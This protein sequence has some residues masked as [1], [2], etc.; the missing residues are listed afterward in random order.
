MLKCRRP[1]E[2]YVE[3]LGTSDFRQPIHQ[4]SL[5][6]GTD[7][8]VIPWRRSGAKRKQRDRCPR[9]KTRTFC[10]Y[11]NG[12]DLI[13]V[14]EIQLF[15]IT[16]PFRWAPASR[17]YL[18]LSRRHSGTRDGLHIDLRTAGLRGAIGQPA[19]IRRNRAALLVVGRG[20]EGNWPPIA[21]QRQQIK[22][23]W[24]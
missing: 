22:V 12:P 13:L 23:L 21:V 18:P 7:G 3:L 11:T 19:T 5:S 8:E 1:V 14:H 4:E 24:N 16:P 17:G 6:V 2:Q 15:A 9:F 20:G 10:L